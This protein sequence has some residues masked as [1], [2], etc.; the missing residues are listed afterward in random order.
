MHLYKS[1][2]TSRRPP[3]CRR[4]PLVSLYFEVLRVLY[5]E[6]KEIYDIPRETESPAV[7]SAALEKREKRPAEV[8]YYKKKQFV[9]Y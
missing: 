2:T 4:S 8:T 1:T 6:T 3:G 5:I 9:I 7:V